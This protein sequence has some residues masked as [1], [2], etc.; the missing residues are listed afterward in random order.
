MSVLPGGV[1]PDEQRI[2]V[3]L[4]QQEQDE[5]VVEGWN[6]HLERFTSLT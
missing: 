1:A 6:L 5:Q 2:W 3:R 4:N